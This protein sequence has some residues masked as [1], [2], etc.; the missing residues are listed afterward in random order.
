MFFCVHHWK[1]GRSLGTRLKLVYNTILNLIATINTM[2]LLCS[3]FSVVQLQIVVL[4]L[5]PSSARKTFFM[6]EVKG[7]YAQ[8]LQCQG[9]HDVMYWSHF[10]QF[11]NGGDIISGAQCYRRGSVPISCQVRHIDERA[12]S[13][14]WRPGQSVTAIIKHARVWTS[15]T[16]FDYLLCR[17]RNT[18]SR[19]VLSVSVVTTRIIVPIITPI[20]ELLLASVPLSV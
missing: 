12:A 19:V 4:C 17:N 20:L 9:C 2:I 15:I 7:I 10:T 6:A 11:A 8:L 1:T 16:A 13:R 5:V 3:H 14:C 18:I